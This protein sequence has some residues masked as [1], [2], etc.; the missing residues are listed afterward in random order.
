MCYNDYQNWIT[1]YYILHWLTYCW[2]SQ[3]STHYPGINVGERVI[4]NCA[5]LVVVAYLYPALV[6]TEYTS[7]TNISI[8]ARFGS[9]HWSCVIRPASRAF[10]SHNHN[11]V[12][13]ILNINDWSN[14][15]V[16]SFT[17]IAIK[18]YMF[19]F[20]SDSTHSESYWFSFAKFVTEA[21]MSMYTNTAAVSVF[22]HILKVTTSRSV[23]VPMC[24]HS[25]KIEVTW[26]LYTS[27]VTVVTIWWSDSD[28]IVGAVC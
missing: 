26:T 5:P 9:I 25:N 21:T 15:L 18:A 7:K 24:C 20:L 6:R 13:H 11:S 27:I 8:S 3:L 16:Y 17:K 4:T 19:F 10:S 14:I 1:A 12:I 23:H 2:K 28:S 22:L